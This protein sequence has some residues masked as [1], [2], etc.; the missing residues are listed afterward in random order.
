MKLVQMKN[1]SNETCSNETCSIETCSNECDPLLISLKPKPMSSI[2]MTLLWSLLSALLWKSVSE[3]MTQSTHQRESSYSPMSCTEI[4]IRII[5]RNQL[6]LISY[7]IRQLIPW[8]NAILRSTL[9]I[10]KQEIDIF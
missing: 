3:M 1:C 8:G 2:R 5:I 9:D 10:K 4:V 6:S 7:S